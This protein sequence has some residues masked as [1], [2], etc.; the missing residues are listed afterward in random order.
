V[1][2][3]DLADP[4]VAPRQRTVPVED[5]V[6]LANAFLQAR[7]FE[8]SDRYVDERFLVHEGGRLLLRG[9]GW[10]DGPEWDLSFRL[11]PLT[12]RIHLYLGYPAG[13]GTLRDLVERMGG[14]EV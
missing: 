12:K 1:R 7:F 14:P 4:P 9:R 8:A 13:L 10:I 6:S 11:G 3:D 2:Y 5:V